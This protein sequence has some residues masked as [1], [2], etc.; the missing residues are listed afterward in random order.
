MVGQAIF[1]FEKMYALHIAH[2]KLA[3]P[4]NNKTYRDSASDF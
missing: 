4:A 3:L 2:G 1:A